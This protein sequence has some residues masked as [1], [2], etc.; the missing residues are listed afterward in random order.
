MSDTQFNPQEQALIR[1]LQEAP[2][3]Q[4]SS[5]TVEA[6]RQKMLAEL[7][8]PTLPASQTVTPAHLVTPVQVV[9]GL[10][11]AI[12]L[13]LASTILL[14][15]DTQNDVEIASSSL[16]TQVM[17]ENTAVPS[18]TMPAHTAT[19]A[20][21]GAS[22][23]FAAALVA[24][25]TALIPS[26]T[27]MPTLIPAAPTADS[28]SLT[29]EASAEPLIVIEGPVQHI[30]DS[31]ITI[32]GF[33]IE[34]A[35]DH[36]ILNII[37]VGDTLRI[38]GRINDEGQVTAGVID[39]LPVEASEDAA[40]GLAGPVEMIENNIV[41]INDIDLALD[42]DDPLLETLKIGDFLSVEGNFEFRE[43]RYVLVVIYVEIIT[44]AG[45]G[46]SPNCY[47]EETGMGMGMGMG[48]WRC[49][50]MAAMGM[51]GMGGMGMGN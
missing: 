27:E 40:V 21:P 23:T 32:F 6:I 41:T 16:K 12:T 20:A 17:Q 49:D 44:P 34:V 2:Q 4:M 36:P 31:T 50:G 37:A 14:L 7:A 19:T 8:N 45:A 48:R 9:A 47:Y 11:M 25:A 42:P 43:N 38:E 30:D 1:R 3:R 29:P 10:A 18:E 35:P 5:H 26:A 22:P 46:I 39:N 24:S 28:P 15:R 13:I 51:G 33:T